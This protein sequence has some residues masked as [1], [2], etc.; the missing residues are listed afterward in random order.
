METTNTALS[1]FDRIN[2]WIQESITVKLL[3]I[4]FLVLILLIPTAWIES[5]IMEREQRAG[6][7]MTEV[8]SSWSGSQ[9]ISGPVLVLPFTQQ[10]VVDRGKE[11]IEI[12]ERTENAFFLPTTL[13]VRG[14]V[15]PTVLHRG[16][17]DAV[18]YGSQ[19]NIAAVFDRPN[20]KALNIQEES[21]HWQDAYLIFGITDLRGIRDNPVFKA[22]NDALQTEPSSNLGISSFKKNDD[23]DYVDYT[24]TRSASFSTSGVV[25][26]LNWENKDRFN[27]NISIEL[28]LKGSKR[29]DFVPAG[30]TTSVSLSGTW[31]NPSFDG[32][33]LP[34]TRE[35]SDSSFAATWKVLHYN[36]PF[37]QQWIGD[38]QHLSGAEFGVKFLIPV[39][40]YQKSTRT[41]KYGALIIILTFIALFLVEIVRKIRIHPFQYILIG[42]ALTIYY[43]LLISFS[44]HIGYNM[45]YVIASAAT[46]ILI[47]LYSTTF[48]KEGKLVA[49]FSGILTLFYTF[50]FVIIL[51]QDFS[52]LLGSL[53][54][55]F[56]VAMLMFFSRNINWYKSVPRPMNP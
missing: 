48:L 13:D 27:G 53:G 24:T 38:N 21:V 47:S 40:Q 28:P 2:A 43:T 10:E 5:L 8:A 3:S 17:F 14:E 41:A 4:G 32:E 6:E 35:V 22:G 26:K 7:V 42:V 20:L 23:T 30:K 55:F 45:A 9:T 54:L 34:E 39:D 19:L 16:I 37:S 18:V 44:E 12:R 33:F 49:L 50:I 11:G 46:V 25:A 51:E 1:F 56:I 52:L 29:L 36:R 15:T 31:N